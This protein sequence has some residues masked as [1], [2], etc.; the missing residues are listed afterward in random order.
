MF[1]RFNRLIPLP[2][3]NKYEI[4]YNT[5]KYN[6]TPNLPTLSLYGDIMSY[7]FKDS[8]KSIKYIHKPNLK[9]PYDEQW[10][11]KDFKKT[12]DKSE[13]ITKIPY[14]E[15]WEVRDFYVP[16]KSVNKKNIDK[17]IEK[18]K[19]DEN[20]GYDVVV[21][22]DKTITYNDYIQQLFLLDKK[23]RCK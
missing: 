23:N 14:E 15:Q 20:R 22:N 7:L 18:K 5:S 6:F 11:C 21:L 10:E 2:G 12:N 17:Y 9:I 4:L 13:L 19:K 8:K 16:N 1:R 3:R